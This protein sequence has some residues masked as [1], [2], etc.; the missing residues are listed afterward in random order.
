MRQNFVGCDFVIN[1]TRVSRL[2]AIIEYNRDK[3]VIIAQSTN[4]TF[5]KNSDGKEVY[6]RWEEL[7]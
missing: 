1:S 6:L 4:G 2:H 5:V 3:F 7:P